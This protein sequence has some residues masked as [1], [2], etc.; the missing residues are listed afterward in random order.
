MNT[1][2]VWS[3]HVP[4]K[5]GARN[6]INDVAFSPD[7]TRVIVAV[8][9]RV[10]LYNAH[11]GDLLESLRGHKD[12]V[13]CVHFSFDG[14]RFA[15]GGSDKIVVIWKITGQG[16]L[17]YNHTASIQT[18]KYNP[19]TLLL[20]S[21]SEVDFGLWTPEQKQV[22]KQKVPSKILSAAWSSDGSFLALGMVSSTLVRVGNLFLIVRLIV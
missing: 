17:K 12:T 15:S 9:N 1:T 13:Y 5:D 19:V 2:T 21:C 18:V 7:G 4:E 20:A 8:G 16:L 14:Q 22:I 11:T 10:L 6:P 3:D